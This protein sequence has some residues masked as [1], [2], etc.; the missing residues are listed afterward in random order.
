M[1]EGEGTLDQ[2]AS[3]LSEMVQM[4][5]LAISD[6]HA[7][8]NILSNLTDAIKNLSVDAI[9]FTGDILQWK[10][11][12]S[13]WAKAKSENRPPDKDKAEIKEEIEKNTCLYHTFYDNMRK[14]G[15]PLF[16]IPGN[17]D[18]PLNQ[19][20]EIGWEE[21]KKNS[22]LHIVHSSFFDLDKHFIVTG[23]GGEITQQGKE[24]YFVL[25]FPRWEVEYGLN[26]LS[27]ISS[28]KILLSHT[29]PIGTLDS[30]DGKHKGCKVINDLIQIH[31]PKWVFC[32]HAHGARGEEIIGDSII[33]N[34]GSLKNGFY[35]LVDTDKEKIELKTL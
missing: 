28:T 2:H 9:V 29:P 10:A 1:V 12:C 5:I 32:G 31:R 26:F 25:Q 18:S 15:L 21:M 17:V 19:Y 23:F 22:K 16:T 14:I 24:D 13:E 20:I 7:K 8:E 34:P 6:W 33:V 30:D 4:K 27:N 11:K 3:V 35:A